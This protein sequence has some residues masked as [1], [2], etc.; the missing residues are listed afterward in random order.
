[1]SNKVLGTK[2][3]TGVLINPKYKDSLFRMLF[4]R[5]TSE[6]K[7][8]L[9]DLYNALNGSHHTDLDNI[10]LYM[11]EDVMY[12]NYKN[13]VSFIVNNE[14]N[15]YEHQSSI[16]PNMPLRGLI[17]AS[18]EYS[19]YMK[20]YNLDA[21]SSR[22]I[23]IPTPKYVVL[24]NGKASY[25]E[26]T[27]LKLSDM[28][29]KE[30]DS[31]DYEW[32]ATV[33]NINNGYNSNLKNICAALKD[34][35]D[36]IELIRYNQTVLGMDDKHAVNTAIDKTLKKKNSLYKILSSSRAEVTE[37]FL[38]E[39]DQELHDKTLLEQGI[40]QGIDI[41]K[42]KKGKEIYLNFLDYGMSIEKIA[43]ICKTTKEH[44]EE[45]INS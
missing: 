5:D 37:M 7:Q 11:L 24:Y 45:I 18:K 20:E 31:G 17:Y 27:I 30:D 19:K 41:G 9:L 44:I 21:Y 23:K 3:D 35:T 1:M 12:I 34:Y 4:G 2:G 13:D 29:I 39:F 32:T 38:C 43:E 10:K 36:F 40:E 14:L 6:S 8:N 33:L 42:V 28:F 16:N 25:P 22:L 15:L 26:K